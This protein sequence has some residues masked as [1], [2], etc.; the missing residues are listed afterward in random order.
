[1]LVENDCRRGNRKSE[2]VSDFQLFADEYSE[3]DRA[4][5]V[6]FSCGETLHGRYCTQWILGSDVR[7]SIA[8]H[9]TK[10]WLFR[11]SVGRVV[12]Y[13]SV[14]TVRWRWPLPDGTFTR[15]PYIPMLGLDHRFHGYPP[16]QPDWRYSHQIMEHLI[17]AAREINQ[18]LK[19]PVDFVLL[20]V[21]ADNN[22]AI[23]LYKHFD[24][25]PVP[26]VT[27]GNGNLVMLRRL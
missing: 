15:L 8:K 12:G 23:R 4:D 16:N 6:G 7:V 22:G 19:A 27:R 11:N 10:V 20:M 9:G 18:G 21:A 13:G 3:A 17:D 26:G 25:R 14:G 2:T 24:F 5:L 1:M